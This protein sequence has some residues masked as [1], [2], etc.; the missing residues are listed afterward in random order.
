MKRSTVFA[1]AGIGIALVVGAGLAEGT[2]R[3]LAAVDKPLGDGLRGFDPMGVQIEPSGTLGYRQR[4]NGALHYANGTTATSNS[5]GYRGPVVS[6]DRPTGTIRV[7]LFGGSTSHGYAVNDDQTIDAYMR[8]ILAAKYPGR[9]FEVVNLALDGYDSYQD[10]Q[11]LIADG[12]R[13]QPSVV[14]LNTGI[15]DVRDAWYPNLREADPRTLIWGDVVNRLLAERARGGPTIWTRAK[16]Y[17]YTARVPGYIREQRQRKAEIAAHHSAPGLPSESIASAAPVGADSAKPRPP[18]P[19]AANFFERHVREATRLS[20]NQGAAVLLSTPPSALPTYPPDATSSQGYW[21]WNA[22]VTQ[23]YRDTLSA[24]LKLIAA[25]E[26][27][28]GHAVGYIAPAVAKPQFLDDC[29]LKPD[30]N[31]AVAE[32]FADALG[33]L[34]KLTPDTARGLATTASR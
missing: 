24:R 17:L 32:A 3:L 16:H 13:L 25:D 8:S 7:L 1:I 12:L 19:D 23:R 29:H 4:P 34:L 22:A 6:L 33:P 5:L 31:R 18:Y 10:L 30:G 21:V 14:I 9:H 2:V 11:R 15:N 20:L 26:H 28:A 27:R